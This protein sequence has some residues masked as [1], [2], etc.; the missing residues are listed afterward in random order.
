[1][2]PQPFLHQ[3]LYKTMMQHSNLV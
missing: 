1:M 3:V 2:K